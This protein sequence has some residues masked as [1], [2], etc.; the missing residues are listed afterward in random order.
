MYFEVVY[1]QMGSFPS[2]E[3]SGVWIF[4]FAERGEMS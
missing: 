4:A 3:M 2:E 1:T